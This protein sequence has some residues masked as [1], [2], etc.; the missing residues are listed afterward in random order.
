MRINE[1]ELKKLPDGTILTVFL[2]GDDW[3]KELGKTYSVIKVNNKLYILDKE[4]GFF[5]LDE[6][7]E[8]GFE[9]SLSLDK[10]QNFLLH[11]TL[12]NE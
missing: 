6:I 12:N 3:E 1:E 4:Q 7:N 9:Y 11:G 8:T 2:Q 5:N 10:M